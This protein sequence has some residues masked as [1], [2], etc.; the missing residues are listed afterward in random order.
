M[1]E[2]NV[3][4]R[5]V[6]REGAREQRRQDPQVPEVRGRDLRRAHRRT[7]QAAGV[8]GS[9][10]RVAKARREP[11]RSIA[12]IRPR[13]RPSPRSA[14]RTRASTRRRL[15]VRLPPQGGRKREP[16]RDRRPELPNGRV[17]RSARRSGSASTGTIPPYGTPGRPSP[18]P[19]RNCRL[20]ARV[21]R[22]SWPSA[23]ARPRNPW[24][25]PAPFS[26]KASWI[27]LVRPARVPQGPPPR[28]GISGKEVTRWPRSRDGSRSGR[29]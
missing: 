22:L 25:R 17:L 16:E 26:A 18:R 10:S 11:C 5:A 28:G 20:H 9:P 8:E 27:D 13:S 6:Q 29:C 23:R 3:P 2:W 15:E 7:R 19:S 12:G 24:L 14:I 21:V 4:L 1:E